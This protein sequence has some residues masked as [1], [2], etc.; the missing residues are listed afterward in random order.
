MGMEMTNHNT[1]KIHKK[2]TQNPQ[3]VS[4]DSNYFS[5]SNGASSNI[6]TTNEQGIP[7]IGF[8]VIISNDNIYI[9]D[10][11]PD[12]A[13]GPVTALS[14]IA[15]DP[16]DALISGTSN[17]VL[18][19]GSI[20]KSINH[21]YRHVGFSW[22][23][24]ATSQDNG[25][26]TVIAKILCY[27]NPSIILSSLTKN[28]FC[29]VSKISRSVYIIL[30]SYCTYCMMFLDFEGF[31]QFIPTTFAWIFSYDLTHRK[32]IIKNLNNMMFCYCVV[33][34]RGSIRYTSSY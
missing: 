15:C 11:D 10:G 17:I 27:K 3:C 19:D 32:K 26:I 2:P 18:S 24:Q 22:N 29:F 14:T 21:F 8:S 20:I 23:I 28:F 25:A 13:T 16:R 34:L 30:L 12:T 31:D 5:C 4:G 33:L 9:L 1:L 7:G 6:G